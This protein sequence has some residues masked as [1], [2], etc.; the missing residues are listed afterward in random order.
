MPQKRD[1]LAE[2]AGLPDQEYSA[3]SEEYLRWLVRSARRQEALLARIA[4]ALETPAA[5]PEPK[6]TRNTK[7]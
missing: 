5:S 4:A 6:R 2:D 1:L 7:G 3:T